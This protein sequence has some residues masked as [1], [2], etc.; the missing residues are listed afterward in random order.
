MTYTASRN[1]DLLIARAGLRYRAFVV[2]AP[3]GEDSGVRYLLKVN[4]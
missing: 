3:A 2:E 1:F 4:P